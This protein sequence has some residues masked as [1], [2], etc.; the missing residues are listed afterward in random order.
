M[1]LHQKYIII[2]LIVGYEYF[3]Y[4]TVL[5]DSKLNFEKWKNI[6]NQTLEKCTDSLWFV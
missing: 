4:I 2:Y 3:T 6:K 1:L 5:N